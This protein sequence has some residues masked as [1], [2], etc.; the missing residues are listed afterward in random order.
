[1]KYLQGQPRSTAN[2]RHAERII[3]RM[4]KQFAV[5]ISVWRNADGWFQVYAKN[6]NGIDLSGYGHGYLWAVDELYDALVKNET[7]FDLP[8]GI[9]FAHGLP[10]VVC[11]NC[12]TEQGTMLAVNS[13]D[14][15]DEYKSTHLCGGCL[16]VLASVISR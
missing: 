16:S 6:D 3:A 7:G 10:T 12:G 9:N 11:D 8:Y 14:G 5:E 1:M 13:M 15:A 2:V 4:E